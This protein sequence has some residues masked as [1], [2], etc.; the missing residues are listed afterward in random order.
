MTLF[1]VV[2]NFRPVVLFSFLFFVGCAQEPEIASLKKESVALQADLDSMKTSLTNMEQKIERDRSLNDFE[3]HFDSIAYLTPGSD[4][5]SVIKTD[6]GYFTIQLSNVQAYA[7][8]S[9]VTLKFGNLTSA[10]INGT[11]GTVEWGRV[12]KDGSPDNDNERSKEFRVNEPLRPGAWT[13][14]AI[15]LETI[16]PT[17]LGF[18]R[19]K[20]L[21]HTGIIL[22]T[23]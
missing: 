3:A 20:D 12:A 21:S 8:G 5:Y 18:V 6:L 13:D 4:G 9:K 11:K 16:P 15:V 10:K 17:E 23:R 7:N 2:F 22:A 14:T 19:V 1:R